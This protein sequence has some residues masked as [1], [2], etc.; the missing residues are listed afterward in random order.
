MAS[1]GHHT[2]QQHACRE[3]GYDRSLASTGARTGATDWSRSAVSLIKRRF[4][5]LRSSLRPGTGRF[6]PDA[7]CAAQSAFLPGGNSE[8][9]EGS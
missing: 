3:F 8:L 6:I 9:F 5:G 2:T 1:E 7:S 4:G